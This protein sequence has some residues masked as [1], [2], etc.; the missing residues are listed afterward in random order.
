MLALAGFTYLFFAED[1]CS[2]VPVSRTV[3]GVIQYGDQLTTAQLID[4]AIVRFQAALA[5]PSIAPGDPIHSLASV[6]LGRALVDRETSS[7][8]ALAVQTARWTSSITPS[9]RPVLRRCR[10]R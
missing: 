8:P 1:F 2:G 5:H 3:G 7:E 4:T 6:G 9:T 10:T